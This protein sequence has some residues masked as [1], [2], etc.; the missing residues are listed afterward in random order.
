MERPAAGGCL[1]LPRAALLPGLAGREGALQAD[2]PGCRL[3]G[4][5]AGD[6]RADIHGSFW[7]PAEGAE[8]G[9]PLPALRFERAAALAVF[10]RCPQPDDD[11]RG[12]QHPPDHQGLFPTADCA[13]GGG[14]GRAGGLRGRFR[15]AGD[16]DGG[17]PGSA[18][19][20][21]IDAA[22]LSAAR[23][24][25]GAG[26]RAVVCGAER[27]LP[28]C[29]AP[30]TVRGADLDVRDAGGLQHP[31]DPRALPLAAGAEPDDRCGAGLPL[32]ASW[33]APE[34]NK[35]RQ[36]SSSGSHS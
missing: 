30:D 5:A 1:A 33:H 19:L 14:S 17:L 28:G 11:Q 2:R 12:G 4:A 22:A 29:E 15:L 18:G 24:G 3:G 35:R 23:D 13:A 36:H 8:R 9:D 10:L 21:C 32:G 34:R 20:G 16:P 6:Q 31:A 7:D 26:I 27:A 25:D